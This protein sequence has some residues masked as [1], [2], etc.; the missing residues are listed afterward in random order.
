[1]MKILR[2]PAF[3]AIFAVIGVIIAIIALVAANGGGS[4]DSVTPTAGIPTPATPVIVAL[5]DLDIRSG[6]GSGF[7]RINILPLDSSLDILGI[8]SDRL[9]YQVLLRDGTTGWVLAGETGARLN[10]DRGIVR[11]I[12]PTLT[13]TNTPTYTLTPTSTLTLTSTNTPSPTNFPTATYTPTPSPT[14]T[15]TPTETPRPTHTYTFTPTYSDVPTFTATVKLTLTRTTSTPQIQGAYPCIA[16]IVSP[17]GATR[18]NVLRRLP[19]T[20]SRIIGSINVGSEVTVQDSEIT[21]NITWYFIVNEEQISGWIEENY[22]QL[23]ESCP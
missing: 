13:P 10:G 11:V 9:W 6:P 7:P 4:T 14:A 21:H 3:Q 18:L 15:A 23:S 5:R 17:L 16:H 20:D 1:M 19:D 12:I 2:D 22:L 8:S